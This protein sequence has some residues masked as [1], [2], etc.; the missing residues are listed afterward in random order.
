MA[1]ASKGAF[2]IFPDSSLHDPVPYILK[3]TELWSG[4]EINN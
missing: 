3:R 4:I 2:V 1:E